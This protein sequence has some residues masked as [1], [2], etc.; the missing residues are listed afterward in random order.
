STFEVKVSTWDGKSQTLKAKSAI[1]IER[2][3]YSTISLGCNNFQAAVV[4]TA[5]LPT[6]A[7]FNALVKL[8]NNPTADA[9]SVDEAVKKIV[10]VTHSPI[11]TGDDIADLS[12]ES[13]IYLNFE[14]GTG[15]VTVNTPG[16]EFIVAEDASNMFADFAA[17]ES[18][19]NITA[20]N[21]GNVTN[22]SYMF[23]GAGCDTTALNSLD[24]TSFN[25]A[26]VTRMDHMFDH[27]CALVSLNVKG[28]NTELVETME[29]MFRKTTVLESLDLSN[30]N[31]ASCESFANF[32]QYASSLRSINLEN[33]TTDMAETFLQMFYFCES[34]EGIDVS[35]F[36]TENATSMD[37]MFRCCKMAQFIN[38]LDKFDTSNV[39]ILRSMFNRCDSVIE[40]DCSSFDVSSS[41]NCQYMFYK[42]MSL[43]KL[44]VSGFDLSDKKASVVAYSMPK[45]QSIRE[46]NYGDS[47]IPNN[48]P[49]VPDAFTMYY[50]D[51]EDESMASQ[52][53]SRTVNVYCS[54]EVADYLVTTDMHYNHNGWHYVSGTIDRI[55]QPIT[56]NLID[57]KT[58]K[59]INIEWPAN[60][61]YPL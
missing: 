46:I 44:D 5:L 27:S 3:K 26:N 39:T 8:L 51:L 10:F 42:C 61:R 30:W 12:S 45:L 31:N 29:C 36:N 50:A 9:S 54:S 40:L 17:L 16:T 55:H 37:N 18:I 7:D 28:W 56:I 58:N 47:F 53:P 32:L 1:K 22:M 49:A 21:T 57:W 4:G 23:S 2:S 13:P 34:L 14:A 60:E 33:F 15:T 59:P 52:N 41:G 19:E 38:G 20:L 6:G 48:L 25:T 11:A 35:S 43:Q 24:L